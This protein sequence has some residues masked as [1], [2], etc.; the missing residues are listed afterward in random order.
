MPNVFQRL[1]LHGP[2]SSSSSKCLTNSLTLSTPTL[3]TPIISSAPRGA[4]PAF[5]RTQISRC[6]LSVRVNV[7]EQRMTSTW[8]G[9]RIGGR[10]AS[11]Q[12]R[13]GKWSECSYFSK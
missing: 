13:I 9:S 4:P 2:F 8:E 5:E 1:C 12:I 6:A 3:T 10:L 11:R 7:P